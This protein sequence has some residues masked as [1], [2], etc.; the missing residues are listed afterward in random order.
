MSKLSIIN[1]VQ[2]NEK[3][4]Q[5]ISAA[6]LREFNLALPEKSQLIGHV[7]F[8]LTDGDKLLAMAKVF[9]FEPVFFNGES[10]SLL[11][12][13]GMVAF[14]PG[15]G[16]GK[17]IVQAISKYLKDNNKTGVGFCKPSNQGFYLKSGLNIDEK[18][19]P[20]FVFRKNGQEIRNP[21][22]QQVVYQDGPDRFMEKVIRHD[23]LEIWIPDTTIW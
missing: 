13:G 17:Q 1:G 19:T 23:V 6:L 15:K 5:Q 8:L 11:G 18:A 20:R 21:D 14:E 2:L 10:F 12:I 22:G 16:Y 4:M 7:F 9:P 3:Q